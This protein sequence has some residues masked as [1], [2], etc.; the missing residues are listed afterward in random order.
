MTIATSR[1]S[2]VHQTRMPAEAAPGALQPTI[3]ALHGRGSDDGDLI[4]LAPYLD[5]R[6]LWIS[7]R[8]PLFLEGGF[9]WYRLRD[10]GVPDQP[11]FEAGLA[12]LERFVDEALQAYPVDPEK[13][14]LLGFSQ[15]GMMAYSLAFRRPAR[16]RGLIAHS[17]YLPLAAIR[18][19]GNGAQS[20]LEAGLRDKLCL[21]L[22][23]TADTVIPAKWAQESRDHLKSLGADVVYHEFP[24]GHHVSDRSLAVMDGWLGQQ[25]A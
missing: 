18:A 19:A 23:G 12:A 22:H 20:D 15:G 24:M 8:A 6:L 25:L 14:Y 1:L 17:S 3:I 5:D 9:E 21:I 4:G 11:T 13:L 16:V 10:I 7:P 2:L